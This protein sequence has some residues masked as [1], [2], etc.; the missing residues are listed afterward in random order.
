MI[1]ANPSDDED[2]EVQINI[3]LIKSRTEEN[4]DHEE[5]NQPHK[6]KPLTEEKDFKKLKGKLDDQE[7]MN[8]KILSTLNRI[9]G[10]CCQISELRCD[11]QQLAEEKSMKVRSSKLEQRVLSIEDNLT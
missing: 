10:K 4:A 7:K 5:S 8:E 9:E 2:S 3:N 1:G 6:F 11:I